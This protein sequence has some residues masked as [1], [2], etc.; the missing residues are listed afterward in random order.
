MP[1]Q[2]AVFTFN[3]FEENTYI[4]YD[5]TNECII[6][7]PGCYTSA[8][9]TR[10]KDFI[11]E[12]KLRPVHLINTHCHIDHV[13]GNRFIADTYQL[14]L[15]AH[16]G[17]IAVLETAASYGKM[18][19]LPIEISPPISQFINE[20]D[21]I[22]F[23]DTE[24]KVLFT[25]GHSP[26]SISLYHADQAILIVGDVLFYGSIGRTDLPG[27]NYDTLI[28]SI[29]NKLLPLGDQVRVYNGHGQ[30]TTIGHERKFN[31]F[32]V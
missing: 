28:S 24:L 14:P 20:G 10:L 23:G 15:T 7:D 32:L 6:I 17:E 8:E 31:P 16:Q 19:G 29:T 3:P 5:Q 26:A 18:I 25:P 1:F 21:M 13:M 30:D 4:L 11:T 12:R 2:I 22:K 27:G 9:K